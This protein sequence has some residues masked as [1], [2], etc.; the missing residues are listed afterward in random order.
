LVAGGLAQDFK[1]GIEL[2]R[3]SIASGRAMEKLEK[4]IVFT[5]K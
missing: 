2:T 1:K 3:E 5:N 4:L